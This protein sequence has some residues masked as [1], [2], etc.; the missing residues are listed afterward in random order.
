MSKIENATIAGISQIRLQDFGLSCTHAFVTAPLSS[1]VVRLYVVGT[2][3]YPIARG[4]ESS[5][6]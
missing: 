1:V 5:K 2:G 6:D 4:R 3:H